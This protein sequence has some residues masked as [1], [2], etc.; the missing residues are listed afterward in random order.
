MGV[1]TFDYIGNLDPLNPLGTDLKSLGD[2][3]LRGIKKVL[4]QSFPNVTG[5]VTAVQ[6]DLN[7]LTGAAAAGVTPTELGY[8][9][10]VT[11]NIQT[12][13][14]NKPVVW[15]PWGIST[16]ASLTLSC[17]T[18]AVVNVDAINLLLS[19][20]TNSYIASAPSK[21]MDLTG[22]A[23]VESV[24]AGTL[25]AG[26]WHIWVIYNGTTVSTVASA[27]TTWGSLDKTNISGYTYYGYVGA[28]YATSSTVVRPFNQLADTVALVTPIAAL[29]GST[30]TT[31]TTLNIAGLVPPNA[32]S[33]KM[34]GSRLHTSPSIAVYN[35]FAYVYSKPHIT[36]KGDVW[37]W[38]GPEG[39]VSAT[40]F[41]HL[42]SGSVMLLTP[43]IVYH[44]INASGGSASSLSLDVTGWKY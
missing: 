43:Q 35:V 16:A 32:K 22:T 18:G 38:G 14:D 19:D 28:V 3:H 13:L 41:Y 2:D 10:G 21:V 5:A 8:L 25:S 23:G 20:G 4:T 1:E 6:G 30:A 36:D 27:S 29:G 34:N 12:Q 39:H 44:H 15:R 24:E 17:S 7:V 42:S 26:W 31:T 11:S 9:D 33:V 37:Q 40:T